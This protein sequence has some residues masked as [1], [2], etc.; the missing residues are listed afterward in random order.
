M[1]RSSVSIYRLIVIDKLAR[2]NQCRNQA[3][4]FYASPS[5]LNKLT[6]VHLDLV[7]IATIDIESICGA[8]PPKFNSGYANA[9]SAGNGDIDGAVCT[10]MRESPSRPGC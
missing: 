5:K 4:Q 1:T 3:V 10:V 6:V 7:K 2:M 9:P 8:V